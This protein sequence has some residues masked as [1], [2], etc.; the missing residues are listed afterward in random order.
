MAKSR[1]FEKQLNCM[2]V[3]ITVYLITISVIAAGTSDNKAKPVSTAESKFKVATCQFPVSKDIL[4]NSIYIKKFIAEAAVNEADIILFCEGALSGYAESEFES[5]EGYDWHNLRA[6]TYEIMALAKKHNIWVVLGSAHY[7]SEDVKPTNCQYIIS[8]QGEIVNRYDKSMLTGSDLRAYTPGGRFVTMDIKGFKCGF[9]ICYDICY[10]EMY[11]AY[12][13]KGVKIMFH[14]FYNARTK[15]KT[16]LDEIKPAWARVRA[17]DNRMWVICSNSSGEHSSWASGIARPDGSFVCL[18]KGQP[19]ILYRTFPDSERTH[20]FPSWTHNK[21]MM[22]L[23]KGEVYHLG[24]T[25]QHP[26]VTNG[27]ALP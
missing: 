7:V 1:N 20:E 5:F 17:A 24:I 13:H 14:S 3:I 25:S 23:P 6:Q 2:F 9:L 11:N 16:I 15:G 12:R 22:A 19:G 27:K 26:R 10:P 21:K 4:S 8:N 18:E